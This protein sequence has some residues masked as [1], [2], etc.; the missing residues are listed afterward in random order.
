MMTTD[1]LD[2]AK[3]LGPFAGLLVLAGIILAKALNKIV[4]R[5]LA[6]FDKLA[7]KTERNTEATNSLIVR[8][9]EFEGE[10]DKKIGRLSSRIDG[11]LGRRDQDSDPPP[12]KRART[13]PLGV[14]I[15]RATTNRED[16]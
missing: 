1:A 2:I 16:D 14:P 6:G 7:E 11:A 13:N 9:V 15:R 5:F 8:T 4:D 10:I 12:T 3:Q